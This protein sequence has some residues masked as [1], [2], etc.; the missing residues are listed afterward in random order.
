LKKVCDR[1]IETPIAASPPM[2]GVARSPIH[3]LPAGPASPPSDEPTM[4]VT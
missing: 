3:P 4:P 2:V 1:S